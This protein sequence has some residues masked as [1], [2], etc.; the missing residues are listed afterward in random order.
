MNKFVSHMYGVPY[1]Y[2]FIGVP[3][4]IQVC[5][6]IGV[7]LFIGVLGRPNTFYNQTQLIYNGSARSGE[8]LSY[9][10]IGILPK[11]S[12]L[13]MAQDPIQNHFRVSKPH[14]G[15]VDGGR[16]EYYFF[17]IACSHS[18]ICWYRSIFWYSS[19]CSYN[20]TRRPHR[21]L[22]DPM[23]ETTSGK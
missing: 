21:P 22:G 11:Y 1:I 19:I 10:R 12:L 18:R 23:L 17:S 8:L 5:R 4:Q 2:I 13:R 3:L 6:Y 16:I 20:R 9:R 14:C 7:L 15:A